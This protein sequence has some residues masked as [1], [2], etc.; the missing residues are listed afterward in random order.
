MK[1]KII[2]KISEGLGNQ[3]FMYANAYA[4]SKKFNLHL[5]I[6]PYSG[7]YKNNLRSYM[8]DNFNIS[9]DIAPSNW[10]F[11]NNYRNF[12][13]KIKIKIDLFK[14]NKSFFFEKRNKDKTTQYNQFNLNKLNKIFYVDGNFESEKYFIDYRNDLLNIFSLKKKFYNNE[15][16]KII[17]NYN[18][19]SI[20]VRQ[21][22]FSE[23]VNNKFNIESINKSNEF[24]TST[25]DYIYR[26]IEFIKTKIDKPKFLLWSNDFTGLDKYFSTKDF[27]Y[28]ENSEDKTI[29]DFFLLTQ[30]KNFIVGP[31]TFNWWGAWLSDK[32]NKICIR[33]KNINPSNNKNFWPEN[34]I[35][36]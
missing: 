34:W 9:S 23:R 27:Q 33:P 28:V 2:V 35:K 32:K 20:C 36:I 3:L 16:L 5:S 4:I 8:L 30:C 14:Q 18:V 22:R 25:V 13:K 24:V 7:F 26:S 21:H 6:D 10:I 1:K 31:S 15:Y 12:I 17:N 29:N 19:V 11:S